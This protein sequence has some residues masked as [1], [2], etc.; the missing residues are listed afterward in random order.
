MIQVDDELYST[1]ATS[2]LLAL[3]DD[4][5]GPRFE[6]TAFVNFFI[7]VSESG[8]PTAN[9][10]TAQLS[11]MDSLGVRR[12]VLKSATTSRLDT[13]TIS[14]NFANIVLPPG[15]YALLAELIH[16]ST[17]EGAFAKSDLA[18]FPA[19]SQD[20][21]AEEL[22]YRLIVNR[23]LTWAEG[24]RNFSLL[25]QRTKLPPAH[26]IGTD[27]P[28]LP[29]DVLAIR[30]Q[31]QGAQGAA[32]AFF[33]L[34]KIFAAQ[35]A[36]QN[37]APQLSIASYA[38]LF[39]L[40]GIG[41]VLLI[42]AALLAPGSEIKFSVLSAGVRFRHMFDKNTI[43]LASRP[44]NFN[45]LVPLHLATKSDYTTINEKEPFS[46][47]LVKYSTGL[48]FQDLLRSTKIG[49][50]EQTT[51]VATKAEGGGLAIGHGF[52]ICGFSN[53]ETDTV[54][55]I[56]GS[57]V[58]APNPAKNTLICTASGVFT[59]LK[60]TFD[61]VSPL[62][63]TATNLTNGTAFLMG[64]SGRTYPV[65]GPATTGAAHDDAGYFEHTFGYTYVA[66][67]ALIIHNA[68]K[69]AQIST[70]II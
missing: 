42:D 21:F 59:G 39:V 19:S 10:V 66:G 41:D 4:G 1:S 70:Q 28:I 29:P 65:F 20:P 26:T 25:D 54:Q 57:A 64:T 51:F 24:D 14:G 61:N 44:T 9:T 36:N 47:A 30:A 38:N 56:Y 35:G 23:E 67:G 18:E 45:T 40:E 53:G 3:V 15:E 48:E 11:I 17:P 2:I 22:T 37:I 34:K 13:I 5:D 58:F 63:V 43:P 27:L 33:D 31:A 60:T 69:Q 6:A 12:V 46:F 52:E 50:V 68:A 32:I 8:A 7:L 55:R 49:S 62:S 16:S